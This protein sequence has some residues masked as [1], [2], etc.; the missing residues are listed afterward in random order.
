MKNKK[1]K[2][3]WANQIGLFAKLKK[4][5]EQRKII[6]SLKIFS[7]QKNNFSKLKKC[8]KQGQYF[9]TKFDHLNGFFIQRF[10]YHVKA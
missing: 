1:K 10:S 9:C 6:K 4:I 2:L 7:S 5:K 3:F 8:F